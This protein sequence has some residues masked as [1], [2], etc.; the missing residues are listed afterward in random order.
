VHGKE[1]V[2]TVG[3]IRTATSGSCGVAS[4]SVPCRP[5]WTVRGGR[6]YRAAS[7]DASSCMEEETP[8]SSVLHH[9]R[10]RRARRR[11]PARASGR[12]PRARW[13]PWP[14]RRRRSLEVVVGADVNFAYFFNDP[15]YDLDTV[16]F[17][18]QLQLDDGPVGPFI[19]VS[20]L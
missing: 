11:R 12:W 2:D 8:R 15:T 4:A 20:I 6:Q 5:I 18:H 3:E 19:L 1:P 16:I 14:R 13:M 10:R 17:S 9:R 7:R